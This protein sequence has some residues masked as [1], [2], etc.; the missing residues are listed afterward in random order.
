MK[1]TPVVVLSEIVKAGR[2]VVVV[3]QIC[4]GI[5]MVVVGAR[6]SNSVVVL[7]AVDACV[8]VTTVLDTVIPI[9]EH[10]VTSG[11]VGRARS[12]DN[13]LDTAHG[14][15]ADAEATV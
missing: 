8:F 10:A 1:V 9:H 7:D 5:C 2:V 12:A 11:S 14:D 6:P 3:Y 4:A 15:S 13:A